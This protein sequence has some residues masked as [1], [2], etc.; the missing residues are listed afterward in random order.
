MKTIRLLPYESPP[1]G[2]IRL[3]NGTTIDRA[4]FRREVERTHG[5]A[6]QG[7]G[8]IEEGVLDA[9]EAAAFWAVASEELSRLIDGGDLL[10]VP[11]AFL[12]AVAYVE[13]MGEE[14][15]ERM[16]EATEA[17]ARAVEAW[18][19]LTRKQE[20][21]RERQ[22]RERTFDLRAGGG[23]SQ[24]APPPLP[25]TRQWKRSPARDFLHARLRGGRP[26][27][28]DR[29]IAEAERLGISR[30]T[31]KRAKKELGI[32]TYRGAPGRPVRWQLLRFP[33][34]RWAAYLAYTDSDGR[35]R[36]EEVAGISTR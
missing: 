18:E 21:E 17:T 28:A 20:R 31:L 26:R 23:A 33:D 10:D 7:M 15:Y 29:L 34:D 25:S 4:E 14:A 9:E 5:R 22:T 19:D 1:E 16:L 32:V 13:A 24:P 36:W 11:V 35:A 3:P 6:V 27:R 8:D 2:S 12:Q 30:R